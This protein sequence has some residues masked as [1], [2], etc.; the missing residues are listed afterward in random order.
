MASFVVGKPVQTNEPAVEVTVSPNAPLPMGR[1]QF[2]L[3]VTDDSGNTSQPD[4]VTII[5]RDSK[6]PTAVL[7]VPEQVEYGSSFVLDGR[8]SSDVPP[9]KVVSYS[10][11]MIS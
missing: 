2:Q 3:I 7:T 1:H 11:T 6:S 5:V 10:F 8:K 4:T 9:G